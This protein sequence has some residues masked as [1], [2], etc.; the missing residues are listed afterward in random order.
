MILLSVA[1]LVF[2]GCRDPQTGPD[3]RAERERKTNEAAR[4]AGE[5]AYKLAEKAKVAAKEAAE[6]LEKAGREAREGWND[7]KRNDPKRNEPKNDRRDDQ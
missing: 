5:E 1:P 2:L 6:K 4:K 3:D 7:A